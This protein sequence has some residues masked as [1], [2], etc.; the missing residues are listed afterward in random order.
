[1]KKLKLNYLVFLIFFFCFTSCSS[2]KTALFD[3]Y[4]YEKTIEIKVETVRLINK[5]NTPFSVNKEKIESLFLNIEKLTEYESNKSNNEITFQ[6][7]KIL[8][9][10]E[11]NLLGGFFK[12]WET[13]GIVS[14]SFS[15]ESQRQILQ[16]FDLLIQYEIKK[17]KESKDKLLDLI[18]LNTLNNG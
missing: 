13:K 3:Q 9:D 10:K 16:A 1:M 14:K 8:S 2:T 6:I 7:W 17:D 5:S 18:N 15:E 11:K 12:L 4:S